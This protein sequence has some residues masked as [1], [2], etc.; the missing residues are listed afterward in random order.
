MHPS[1]DDLTPNEIERRLYA[2]D[3]FLDGL[4]PQSE[5]DVAELQTMFGSTPVELP[6]R[7]RDAGAVLDRIAQKEGASPKPSAFGKLITMMRTEKKLSIDQLAEKTDLDADELR[8]IES[9]GGIVASPLVVSVLADYFKLQPQK[10]MRLAG[11]TRES[12]DPPH[13]D[14]LSVAACAKPNFESLD[15]EEKAL[16]HEFVKQLRKKG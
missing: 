16:F 13:S 1:H 11:L 9:E 2:A 8:H 6:E 7:L 4:F 5:A 14:I 15:P 3:Q 12:R 10:A